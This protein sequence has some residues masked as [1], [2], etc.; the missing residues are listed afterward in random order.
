MTHLSTHM[1]ILKSE[2][3][4][5]CYTLTRRKGMKT[6]RIR[7][8]TD[9]SVGVSADT[10]VPLR[11]IEGFVDRKADWI[12]KHTAAARPAFEERV[13]ADGSELK[14]FGEELTLELRQ[15]EKE[16]K[17]QG[18]RLLAAI[19]DTVDE[20]ALRGLLLEFIAERGRAVLGEHYRYFLEKSGYRG[21]PPTL[22][23]KLL[24]SKWGHCDYKNNVIM[25][26][27]ALC[28]LPEEL[29]R[30][31]AAHEVAHLLVSSHSAEFYSV[32]ERLYP[33]FHAFDRELRKYSTSLWGN[34][35]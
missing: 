34:I 30:Y 21:K 4:G 13:L 19:P 11:E 1:A 3:T 22:A 27:F 28:G 18:N 7:I 15:G 25:L 23:L 20:T 9:G 31:V 33:G 35:L 10:A 26:N 32:G 14:I 24:K 8:K 6:I 5:I 16:I 12:K 17:R 29:I 2:Q